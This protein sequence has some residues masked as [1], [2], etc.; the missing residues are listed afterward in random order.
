M[1]DT[2]NKAHQDNHGRTTTDDIISWLPKIAMPLLNHKK[3]V[4]LNSPLVLTELYSGYSIGEDAEGFYDED[5][6]RIYLFANNLTQESTL[7]VFMHELFHRMET[8][9]PELQSMLAKFDNDMQSRFNRAAAGYGEPIEQLA[10]DRVLTANPHHDDQL[11]EFKAYLVSEFNTNPINLTGKVKAIVRHLI[12]SIRAA[13]IRGGL[14]LKSISPADLSAL[15]KAGLSTD[16]S[17]S[18]T[19]SDNINKAQQTMIID[20]IKRP[21]TNS[22]GQPIHP[23][24]QGIINFWKW[25]GDSQSIDKEGRPLVLYHATARD[26]DVFEKKGIKP[27]FTSPQKHLGF[28]FTDNKA[29]VNA[30]A[31]QSG[32]TGDALVLPVYLAINNPKNESVDKIGEIED[33]WRHQQA[34]DYRCALKQENRDGII[35]SGD[36]RKYGNVN[37]FVVFD[38]QQ[39]KSAVGNTGDFSLKSNKIHFSFAGQKSA[40]ANQEALAEAVQ[41]VSAGDDAETIRQETGWHQWLDSKWRYEIDD[42]NARLLVGSN[43]STDPDLFADWI[44]EAESR[45]NGVTLSQAL[46]HDELFAAYPK[47]Q[48]VRLIVDNNMTEDGSFDNVGTGTIRIKDPYSYPGWAAQSLSIILHEIQHAIQHIEGFALGSNPAKFAGENYAIATKAVIDDYAKT[49]ME[50]R[51]SDPYQSADAIYADSGFSN[52]ALL[53]RNNTPE[54]KRYQMLGNKLR[55]TLREIGLPCNAFVVNQIVKEGIAIEKIPIDGLLK[56]RQSAGEVEARNTQARM[57]LIADDRKNVAP[58]ETSDTEDIDV[59]ILRA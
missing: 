31:H 25:F 8:I 38:A 50:I 53:I 49:M 7:G 42:S 46:K 58:H 45:E 47:L 13:L 27:N 21:M 15:A 39:I 57:G 2:T 17:V 11:S 18:S 28:F 12:G 9:D 55:N 30:Y 33:T 29:Y 4:I 36:I 10:Y 26:F 1:A 24:T 37:E 3:L 14:P 5:D 20:G 43:S 59:I 52:E 48:A 16:K 41:K 51:A 35:F 44:H 32:L 54:H 40:S 34:K 22:Q 23:T 56:Y 19:A 6:D